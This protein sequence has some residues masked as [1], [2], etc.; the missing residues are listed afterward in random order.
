MPRGAN[1]G[2]R[3]QGSKW[4]TPKRRQ[5]IYARDGYCCI[6]CCQHAQQLTLDHVVPREQRG[7]N[8]TS[9]LV[10][11]CMVCNRDRGKRSLYEYAH[12]RF[13][14]PTVVILRVLRALEMSLDQAK[15]AA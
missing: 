10:T 12:A 6:W 2:N 9:N 14:D 3:G 7:T 5:A 13:T 8:L 4:I 15:E 11:A 1:A